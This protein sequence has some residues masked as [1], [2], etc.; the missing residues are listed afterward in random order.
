MKTDFIPGLRSL[1]DIALGETLIIQRPRGSVSTDA[2]KGELL[3]STDT[4][5]GRKSQGGKGW[6]C[7]AGHETS[8][9]QG[10]F[11]IPVTGAI[12][13]VNI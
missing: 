1:R 8:S 6:N 4:N 7:T 11:A 5:S 2:M 3:T 10:F 12:S 9:S 13:K